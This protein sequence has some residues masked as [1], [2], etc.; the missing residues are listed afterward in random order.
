M[1]STTYNLAR[2]NM[3]L[4]DVNY[5]NFNIKNDNTLEQPQHLDKR[6]EAIV[7]NPPF[8]AHWSHK[9][10]NTD[11]RFSQYGKLAP[12]KKADFAFIQH[13]IHQLDDN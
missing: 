6:F 13:M 4:H 9:L 7:A 2:M 8:S 10:K 3:I 1:N 11:D 5:K 12:E